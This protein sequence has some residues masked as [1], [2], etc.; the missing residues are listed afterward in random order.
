C[1][2]SRLSPATTTRTTG[3]GGRLIGATRRTRKLRR[4]MIRPAT[5]TK[6]TG[7]GSTT[8]GATRRATRPRRNLWIRPA[9]PIRRTGTGSPSTSAAR[10][11]NP[12]RSPTL[13]A[14]PTRRTGTG[15]RSTWTGRTSQRR[16]NPMLTCQK[17]LSCKK[18]PSGSARLAPPPRPLRLHWPP[19]PSCPCTTRARGRSACAPSTWTTGHKRGSSCKA[20]FFSFTH[21]VGQALGWYQDH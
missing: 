11:G 20:S 15:S 5:P 12:T 1:T 7:T 18:T 4:R 16:R 6:R 14:M 19:S 13:P 8:T 2:K 9:T 21:R 17:P 10:T 3:T